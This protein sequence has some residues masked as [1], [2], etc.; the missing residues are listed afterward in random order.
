MIS[1]MVYKHFLQQLTISIY[2]KGKVNWFRTA[3]LACTYSKQCLDR[4]SR[5]VGDA[6]LGFLFPLGNP[7]GHRLMDI[8]TYYPRCTRISC[9][10]ICFVQEW[11]PLA[12]EYNMWCEYRTLQVSW[13]RAIWLE[14]ARGVE[15]LCKHARIRY[16]GF[17]FI[18]FLSPICF[19]VYMFFGFSFS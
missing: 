15:A 9:L 19:L 13:W 6:N 7:A 18:S 16:R 11:N 14:I 3:P 1:I 5:L 2:K 10:R 12:K 4:L 8:I 17:L